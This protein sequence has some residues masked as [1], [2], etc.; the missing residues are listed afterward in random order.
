MTTSETE[1]APMKGKEKISKT[2]SRFISIEDRLEKVEELYSSVDEQVREVVGS[3]SVNHET[4]QNLEEDVQSVMAVLPSDIDEIVSSV[5]KGMDDLRSDMSTKFVVLERAIA[6]GGANAKGRYKVPEQEHYKGD[7]DP[8]EFKTELKKY[9]F[10]DDVDFQARME[11]RALKQKGTIRDYVKSFNSLI[12]SIP[13]M[14]EEDRL[15]SFLV[16]LRP[17]TAQELRRR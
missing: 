1:V 12:L 10:P 7:R 16:G 8:K 4:I 5:R 11:L 15:F 13:N 2:E 17:W 6:N 14:S 9:F 3:R